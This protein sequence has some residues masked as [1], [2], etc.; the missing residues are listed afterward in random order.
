MACVIQNILTY[1]IKKNFIRKIHKKNNIKIDKKITL[2]TKT[3]NTFYGK[4]GT[5]CWI[6]GS[7][8]IPPN[9]SQSLIYAKE[10]CDK[11]SEGFVNLNKLLHR[12]HCFYKQTTFDD[13]LITEYDSIIFANNY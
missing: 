13:R 1:Y 9:Q 10:N 2:L 4:I 7:A 8:R 5:S 11:I 6:I 3:E 12:N